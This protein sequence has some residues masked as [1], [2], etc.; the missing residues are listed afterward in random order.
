MLGKINEEVLQFIPGEVLAKLGIEI[1]HAALK[2]TFSDDV[3]SYIHQ[4]PNLRK[5]QMEHEDRPA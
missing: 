4:A 2:L 5:L 3:E 1:S